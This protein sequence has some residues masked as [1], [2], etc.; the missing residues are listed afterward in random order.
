[1]RRPRQSVQQSLAS[2]VLGFELIVMFLA[3]L[4]AFG[5]KALPAPVALIGGAVLCLVIVLTLAVLRYRWGVIVGW[6]VQGVIVASGILVPIMFIIGALFAGMWV[7][8]M[9]AGGRID[10]EK[11]AAAA[12]LGDETHGR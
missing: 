12:Q 9:V 4:V 5:L 11:A 8:A 3:A 10:R 2:I 7:Y 1:M 6:V